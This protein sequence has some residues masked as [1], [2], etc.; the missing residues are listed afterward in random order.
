LNTSQSKPE[1]VTA[2]IT[3]LPDNRIVGGYKAY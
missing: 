2:S 1:D 3:R